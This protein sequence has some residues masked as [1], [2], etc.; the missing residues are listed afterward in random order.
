MVYAWSPCRAT[1]PMRDIAAAA[2]DAIAITS[3]ADIAPSALRAAAGGGPVRLRSVQYNPMGAEEGGHGG[4]PLSP[5]S[6]TTAP[7][8]TPCR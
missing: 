5:G 4:S 6:L 3:V 7:R 2:F 1:R 8:P